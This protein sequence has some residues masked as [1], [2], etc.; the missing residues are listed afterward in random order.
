MTV[1]DA[2]RDGNAGARHLIDSFIEILKNIGEVRCLLINKC[3]TNIG[4][5]PVEGPART[6]AIDGT[7][8]LI[9]GAN[10]KAILLLRKALHLLPPET[11]RSLTMILI[12]SDPGVLSAHFNSDKSD[13][14]HPA[15][16]HPETRVICIDTKHLEARYVW[17]EAAHARTFNLPKELLDDW[18]GIADLTY[19]I[20]YYE[21]KK[22]PTCGLVTRYGATNALE[23]IATWVEYAYLHLGNKTKIFHKI[24]DPDPR[25]MQKLKFL[26]KWRFITRKC[27][28]KLAPLL[29]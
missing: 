14:L 21:G 11:R 5:L 24:E 18:L 13:V 7:E 16:C 27:F 22:F 8:I 20:D 23:D 3:L 17:H 4:S 25:F 1:Y 9:Y 19:G 6:L 26:L 29:R 28:K 10:P 15:H 12:I 2:L